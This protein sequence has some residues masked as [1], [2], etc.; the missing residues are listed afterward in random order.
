MVLGPNSSRLMEASSLFVEQVEAR[1]DDKKGVL[2]YGFSEKPVLSYAANWSVSNY[3]IVRSYSRKVAF[4]PLKSIS[5]ILS[6][7]F[8]DFNIYKDWIYF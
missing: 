1:D 3:I 7:C 2:L 6:G 4:C 5:T 8:I